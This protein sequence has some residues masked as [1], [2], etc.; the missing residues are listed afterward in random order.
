MLAVAV[1]VAVAVAAIATLGSEVP[2]VTPRAQEVEPAME[3]ARRLRGPLEELAAEVAR[4][5]ATGRPVR[6]QWAA[7]EGTDSRSDRV[8]T[9]EAVVAVAM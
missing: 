1:A 6:P 9:A 5:A 4:H 7:S 2:G 8:V 3:R